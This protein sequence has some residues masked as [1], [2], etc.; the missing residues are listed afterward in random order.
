VTLAKFR[1]GIW[2]TKRTGGL[3]GEEHI[4]LMRGGGKQIIFIVEMSRNTEV[5][6]GAPEKQMPEINEKI[7]I[8][9]ILTVKNATEQRKLMEISG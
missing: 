3:Y 5:E 7:V 9:K 8:R 4:L 6:R 2:K 1:L